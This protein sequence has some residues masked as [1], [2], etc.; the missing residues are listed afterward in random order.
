MKIA[1]LTIGSVL[2]LSVF[3]GNIRAD[4]VQIFAYRINGQPLGES[5]E[6]EAFKM[7]SDYL[8]FLSPQAR[9]ARLKQ[10]GVP[11]PFTPARPFV[12]SG[13]LTFQ[14][15]LGELPIVLVFSRSGSSPTATSQ[16]VLSNSRRTHVLHVTI[17]D[18][19]YAAPCDQPPSCTRSRAY[20]APCLSPSNSR[21]CRHHPR[22][23]WRR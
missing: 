6:V 15:D 5:F 10:Q 19:V 20:D 18:P 14:D 2:F 8:I 13:V 23:C 17:P 16:L 3:T 7:P 22:R 9:G 21:K 12:T 11:I 1:T 4:T